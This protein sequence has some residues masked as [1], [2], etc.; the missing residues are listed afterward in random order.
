MSD[1][2]EKLADK[3]FDPFFNWDDDKKLRAWLRE[4][5][6]DE[7]EQFLNW[8]NFSHSRDRETLGRQELAKLRQSSG[9]VTA[10]FAKG[11]NLANTGDASRAHDEF[12]NWVTEVARWLEAETGNPALVAKWSGLPQSKLVHAGCYDDSPEAWD[13]FKRVIE[14]RLSWLGDA[15]S[16]QTTPSTT[17]PNRSGSRKVFIV[18]GHDEAAR[19]TVARF[20]TNL[21]FEPVILHEQSN[22][23]R[24]L[25]EKFVANSDVGFAII[26]L[27]PDDVGGKADDT[28]MRKRAR[29]NVVL[30]WGYFIGSLGRGRVCA[31]MKSDVELPSDILGIV[32]EPLDE[33]GA[34]KRNLANELQ[35]AGLA[36]DWKKFA[37]A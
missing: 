30:E 6:P 37:R 29:Q 7:L 26:L 14:H 24:T 17:Q 4:Q 33:Y 3:F 1:P 5:D 15:L 2:Q 19:E 21:G 9:K 16:P 8:F 11:R 35:D 10:L 23:G 32:W 31:L 27:T 12:G 28:Q 13:H 22:R 20:L 18:H 36:V 25:I 34:W